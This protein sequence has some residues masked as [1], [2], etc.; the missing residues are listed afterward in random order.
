MG[1]FLVISLVKKG[2]DRVRIG[3]LRALRTRTSL[4]CTS[5]VKSMPLTTHTHDT[6][7]FFMVNE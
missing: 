2:K 3:I 6:R 1:S 4:G 5:L 7:I